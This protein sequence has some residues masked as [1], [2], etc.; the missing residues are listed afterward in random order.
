MHES[1][2]LFYTKNLFFKL[3][4]VCGSGKGQADV[5]KKDYIS[6]EAV[7]SGYLN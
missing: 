6:I 7:I 2:L 1:T 4:F 3:E 5:V